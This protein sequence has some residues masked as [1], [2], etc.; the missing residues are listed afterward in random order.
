VSQAGVPGLPSDLSL[1]ELGSED[2]AASAELISACDQT[3]IE[4]AP[5]GWT[6]PS[7]ESERERWREI[8]AE[9]TR[10]RR[11]AFNESGAL[12][13]LLTARQEVEDDVPVEGVGHV[14]ALFVHPSRWREGIAAAMLAEGEMLMRERGLGR[15]KL[16]TPEWA[17]ARRFYEAQG[18]STTG[19][20]EFHEQWD[21]WTVTYEKSLA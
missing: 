11:G 17:P 7:E 18:W 5:P 16:R 4:F 20:R 1:R 19:E 2:A 6:P 13:A 12:V 21:M 3:Y 14:G 8:L 10:L 9:P 15:A